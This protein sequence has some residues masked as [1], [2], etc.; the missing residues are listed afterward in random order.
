MSVSTKS[1]ISNNFHELLCQFLWMMSNKIALEKILAGLVINLSQKGRLHHPGLLQVV[2]NKIPLFGI[3]LDQFFFGHLIVDEDIFKNIFPDKMHKLSDI[4]THAI[5]CGL[6]FTVHQVDNKNL[7]CL[8][9][10]Q[11]LSY[12]FHEKI[13]DHRSV[14]PPGA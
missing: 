9:R 14:Q 5:T 2:G 6:A 12:S 13:G 10:A 3:N 7:L 1:K 11:G 4:V 8:S